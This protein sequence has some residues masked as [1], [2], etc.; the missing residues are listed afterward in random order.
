[1][2]FFEKK[3]S[4]IK[5]AY[6]K[7]FCFIYIGLCISILT[8]L[9]HAT[10]TKE[11]ILPQIATNHSCTI[12]KK[13]DESTV[14]QIWQQVFYHTSG[15]KKKKVNY[16]NT[17][18]QYDYEYNAAG[19]LTHKLMTIQGV[20]LGDWQYIYN[21][22]GQKVEMITI[23]RTNDD[24]FSC[25]LYAY[26]EQG[27]L[28]QEETYFKESGP[29]A[30]KTE[31]TN[32]ELGKPITKKQYGS[33]GVLLQRIEYSYD[34]KNRV[35][36]EYAYKPSGNLVH[37]IVLAYNNK[38]SVTVSQQMNKHKQPV[39]REES[40][41]NSKGLKTRQVALEAKW[42]RWKQVKKTVFLYNPMG[43]LQE[44]RI[45]GAADIVESVLEYEYE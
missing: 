13:T 16:G 26:D 11:A 22:D 44:K 40:F 29:C 21:E 25:T 37:K 7:C 43:V 31:W 42:G 3:N 23:Y 32:N 9:C 35:L 8:Y 45:Y 4:V 20:F 18:T 24:Y 38:D 14:A 1:M 34:N 19:V 41:F 12:M 10:A 6:Q 17:P 27:F 39:Y 33:E 15:K 5:K 28:K 2:P 30:F 36:T